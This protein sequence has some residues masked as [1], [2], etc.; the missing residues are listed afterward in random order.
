MLSNIKDLLETDT[1]NQADGDAYKFNNEHALAQLTVTGCLNAT[2]YASAEAQLSDVLRLASQCNTEY[3]AKVAIYGYEKGYM[4]DIPALLTMLV[5]ARSSTASQKARDAQIAYRL[6]KESNISDQQLQKLLTDLDD[7]E[8]NAGDCKSALEQTFNKVI[9]TSKMLRNFVHIL[10]TGICGKKSVGSTVK[11][12][13]RDWFN[14]KTA[15]EIFRYSVGND[16]TMADVLSIAHPKPNDP[17]KDALF[18][19]L[20]EREY[21]PHHLPSLLKQFEDWKSG[22]TTDVPKV[23]FEMLTAHPLSDDQWKQIAKNAEWTWLC[24]NLNTMIR[25]NVFN[26][27]DMID[28]VA[29][30]I[31]DAE[32]IRKVK[33]FP[34]QLMTAYMN[35]DISV[36]TPIK[37]A[38]GYAME[39]STEN[40]QSLGGKA[41]VFIDVSGSMNSPI[42][43]Y[44]KG[45]T[46]CVRCVDVAALI[47]SVIMRRNTDTDII[48]FAEGVIKVELNPKGSIME[49]AQALSMNCGGTNCAA[50][51][52]YLNSRKEEGDV[53]I[54]VSDN[55]SWI[56]SRRHRH[57]SAVMNEWIRWRERNPHSKLVC[58]DLTPN[59]TTQAYERADILNI[60]GFSDNMFD[61]INRFTKGELEP[62]HWVSEIKKIEL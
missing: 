42:T 39:I 51:L 34:Y 12:L 37:E 58:I 11:K 48:P 3:I 54:Y 43:G 14:S 26:D 5:A 38:L 52:S 29:G 23:S 2:Y 19:W 31:A 24:K 45:S 8:Q 25:H 15:D 32:V 44:R 22:K 18:G 60:G 9:T 10:R 53:L 27:K 30:R 47:A 4:R 16:P 46:S 61:V 55:E 36:P 35:A 40:I 13:I 20:L 56:D 1:T 50:P 49:N 21:N 17:E 6:A 41:Y 62:N 28:Y 59:A 7:A 57:G 33:V